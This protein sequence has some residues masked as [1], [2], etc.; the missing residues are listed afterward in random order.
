MLLYKIKIQFD[1]VVG[2]SKIVL[3]SNKKIRVIVMVA[4]IFKIKFEYIINT[5]QYFLKKL[6]IIFI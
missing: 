5:I 6:K 2:F 4:K 3:F 1:F